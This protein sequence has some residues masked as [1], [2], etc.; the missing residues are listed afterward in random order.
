MA[1]THILNE[2]WTSGVKHKLV[3][4][5][6]LAAVHL[7]LDVAQVRVVDHGAEVGNQQPEGELKPEAQL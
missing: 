5:E 2:K 7:E 1:G 4:I 3:G 6:Q